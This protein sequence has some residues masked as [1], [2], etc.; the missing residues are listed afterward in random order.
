MSS[1][2]SAAPPDAPPPASAALSSCRCSA[3][4]RCRSAVSAAS[5]RSSAAVCARASA[6]STTAALSC[7]A[8]R[9]CSCEATSTDRPSRGV[10]SASR[11]A[12]TSESSPEH[13]PASTASCV[14]ARQSADASGAK[15]GLS[16][17]SSPRRPCNSPE[18]PNLCSEECSLTERVIGGIP[19]AEPDA[20]APKP[21]ATVAGGAANSASA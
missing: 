4:A 21:R 13:W 2:T 18:K 15:R 8:R 9:R 10:P 20:S 5:A 19:R 17:L 14:S 1:R 6:R 11:A 7:C 16:E 12:P 3:S